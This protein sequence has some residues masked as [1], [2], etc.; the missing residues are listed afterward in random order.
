MVLILI[1]ILVR[2]RELTT[3][4]K[5]LL[6]QM[7]NQLTMER[8][9]P[10]SAAATMLHPATTMM[11]IRIRIMLLLTTR[12]QDLLL[13]L[14]MPTTTKKILHW[15]EM[16]NNQTSIER[17]VPWS[18]AIA[19]V[20][21]ATAMV[22]RVKRKRLPNNFMYVFL[23]MPHNAPTHPIVNQPT[24]LKWNHTLLIGIHVLSKSK[25]ARFARRVNVSK[26]YYA[27][28]IRVLLIVCFVCHVATT[29]RRHHDLPLVV[30]RS[31]ILEFLL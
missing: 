23:N 20:C 10:S 1:L 15:Q 11:I 4:K 7:R 9:V 31:I 16:R 14:I 22:N 18:F 27:C 6:C 30:R 13:G 8:I 25:K 26:I 17:I 3:I 29:I 21:P 5:M 28:A 24:V 19:A 12:S 2:I